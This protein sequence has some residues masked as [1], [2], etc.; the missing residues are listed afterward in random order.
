MAPNNEPLKIV[1]C[2][3]LAAGVAELAARVGGRHV[4]VVDHDWTIGPAGH[5]DL[6]R[7]FHQATGR[8]VNMHESITMLPLGPI[9]VYMLPA[10]VVEPFLGFLDRFVV[11]M[12]DG[13]AVFP[14]HATVDAAELQPAQATE[15]RRRLPGSHL[16]GAVTY[17]ADHAEIVAARAKDPTAWPVPSASAAAK[18]V[19]RPPTRPPVGRWR[20]SSHPIKN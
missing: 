19:R 13:S 6:F 11:V 2:D 5:V 7:Q 12:P 16:I 15:V 8:S 20:S 4:P 18:T 14:V 10:E 3:S 1:V 9:G 17:P